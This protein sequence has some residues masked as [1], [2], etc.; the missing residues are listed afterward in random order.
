MRKTQPDRR[1]P[2]TPFVPVVPILGILVCFSMMYSL[3]WVNWA[4]LICLARD[5][6]VHLLRLQPQI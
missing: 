4:R 6:L 1:A 5:R 3:G 2:R